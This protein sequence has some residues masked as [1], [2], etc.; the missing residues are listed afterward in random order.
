MLKINIIKQLHGS[1]GDMKL[2]I[3]LNIKIGDFLAIS[4]V[5]GS[6]K[7]T[8]LRILAG[9]EEAD[10]I[11]QYNDEIWLNNKFIL[12]TQKRNI[13]FLFQDYALFPNMT[14]KENLLYVKNDIKFCNYLLEMTEL[15]ALK[16]KMPYNLSGGQK[17]RVALCRAMMNQPK[18]LLM[19]EPFSA[20]DLKMKINY[21]MKYYYYIKNL[22]PL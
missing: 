16:D 7:T 18:L 20:L 3:N 1:N 9:L 4:G 11:I 12:P 19:D 13:G 17:Q 14:V 21:N 10:G 15:L 8:I 5:S 2:D 22:K 6:G